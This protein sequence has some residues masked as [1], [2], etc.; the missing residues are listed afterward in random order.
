LLSCP[1]GTGHQQPPKPGQ[2]LLCCAACSLECCT[3]ESCKVAR[4]R[5]DKGISPHDHTADKF[6]GQLSHAHTLRT[7]HLPAPSN[8]GQRYCDVHDEVQR[9]LSQVLQ[10]VR[11]RGSSP[12]LMTWSGPAFPSTA[13]GVAKRRGGELSLA[14]A[15]TQWTRVRASFP[16]LTP[17]GQTDP[18]P[19]YQGQIYLLPR[20]G[21]GP[22]LLSVAADEGQGQL[23]CSHESRALSPIC[24]R[25]WRQREEEALSFSSLPT[26]RRWV[27]GPTLPH[28]YPWG[29]ITHSSCNI[30]G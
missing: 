19:L 14:N 13:G 4:G 11:G 18:Q 25:C 15:V 22:A 28:S 10:V 12:A 3:R 20:W 24:H 1:L 29:L 23:S 17:W 6:W 27:A 7:V 30:Q 21:V 16:M 8:Q 5:L 9:L 2:A 26:H